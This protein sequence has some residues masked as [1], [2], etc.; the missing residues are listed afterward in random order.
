MK[1]KIWTL[2]LVL[3]VLTSCEKTD[4]I[5]DPPVEKTPEQYL[6]AKTWKTDEARIQFA[7]SL[8]QYYKRGAAGNTVN[9]D[10]DSIKF[11]TNKTGLYFYLGNQYNTT[12]DFTDPEKTKLTLA[13]NFGASEPETLKLENITVNNK[14]FSYSQFPV[15]GTKYLASVR[16]V[17]N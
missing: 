2:A 7:S 14:Y 13:I 17:P 8:T 1:F 4:P 12:W 5:V 6:V 11:N 9:Y 15:V 16:R 3:A 10:S